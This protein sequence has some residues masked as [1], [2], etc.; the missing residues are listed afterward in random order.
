M[1]GWSHGYNVEQGY[2]YGAYR[3][4]APEWMDFAAR[5]RGMRA[6]ERPQGRFRYLEL[7]CGQG[8][9]LGILAACHPE[10]EF[11][12]VDFNPA[13]VAHARG[14]AEAAGLTNV[15]FME[16]DFN[17]LAAHWPADLGQFQYVALHGIYSWVPTSVRASIA[18]C[19]EHATVPGA[20][21]YNSYNSLPGWASAY[22]LQHV[23]RRLQLTT[24]GRGTTVIQNGLDM[25]LEFEK[26]GALMFKSLPGLKSRIERAKT[27]NRA[28]LVQEYLHDHWQPLWFSQ[29]AGEMGDAK[30]EFVASAT[31]IE[32][33]FPAML[34]EAQR[35]LILRTEDP[36]F[37][38]ELI[39][40]AINQGFRR[41]LYARGAVRE[42]QPG[43]LPAARVMRL[44]S[45]E[46]D[47]KIG[48]P[49][50]DFTLRG[51]LPR[52]LDQ[53][54][55]EGPQA[56]A[57]LAAQPEIARA[58]GVGL[59]RALLGLLHAGHLALHREKAQVQAAVR[60]NQ[61]VARRVAAQ[62]APYNYLAAAAIGNCVA[63]DIPALLLLDIRARQPQATAPQ[64]VEELGKAM[65]RAGRQF[66]DEGK[67]VS[68]AQKQAEL[69]RKTVD[70]FLHTT[71]PAWIAQGAAV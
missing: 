66:V 52:A 19:I 48:T 10:A 71:L 29:V 16:A 57:M 67:P 7:G 32:N 70:T 62:N 6:P 31:V 42:F 40:C 61:A 55:R 45:I 36:V 59:R 5:C 27:Q 26:S 20:L 18:R 28:Y 22:P 46:E 21:V 68:D 1:S 47:M 69:L 50:G 24:A 33:E 3:E 54:L 4:I 2:T 43:L 58:G 12:G 49:A 35:Q 44:K 41:D 15:R 39:D 38:Q 56:V 65:A 11:V 25:L 37:Q 64:M 17:A 9:G 14:L 13:H 53:A 8:V 30:L 60:F 51:P 63:T 23:L 34:P